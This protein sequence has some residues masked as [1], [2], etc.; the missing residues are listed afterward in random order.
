M[1]LNFYR[2]EVS[3]FIYKSGFSVDTPKT[4][5]MLDEEYSLLK[6]SCGDAARMQHQ[7]Y[8][9][10]FLLFEI[11]AKCNM[12]LDD[13]WNKG[14][15]KKKKYLLTD[16]SVVMHNKLVRDNIPAIYEDSGKEVLTKELCEE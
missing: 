11:A 9:M 16:S 15:E 5:A 13:E 10:L 7:V 14:K 1:S 8:D 3:E 2:D 12:D 6:E 4:F